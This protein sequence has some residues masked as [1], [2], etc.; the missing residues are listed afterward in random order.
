MTVCR[1]RSRGK[2]REATGE[3]QR[4]YSSCSTEASPNSNDLHIRKLAPQ[5]GG[6][7]CVDDHSCSEKT[8]PHFVPRLS[9]KTFSPSGQYDS[10]IVGLPCVLSFIRYSFG[11]GTLRPSWEPLRWQIRCV[12]RRRSVRCARRR[13]KS[14]IPGAPSKVSYGALS[15]PRTA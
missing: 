11:Q 10:F 14:E 15:I 4:L 13:F 1:R 3:Y 2:A 6:N 9:R 8:V 7:V 12:E 5:C